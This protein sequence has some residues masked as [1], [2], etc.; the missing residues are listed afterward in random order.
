MR[1]YLGNG[2]NESIYG[3]LERVQDTI[4]KSGKQIEGGFFFLFSCFL[5][6]LF[7][8]PKIDK[9]CVHIFIVVTVLVVALAG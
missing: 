5:V 8:L 7:F 6:F 3:I 9:Y 1:E 2:R 4:K